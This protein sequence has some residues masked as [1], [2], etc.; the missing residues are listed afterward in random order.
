MN[1][2]PCR[3]GDGCRN[4]KC[5]FAHTNRMKC[6]YLSE[7]KSKLCTFDHTPAVIVLPKKQG[8]ISD[9]EISKRTAVIVQLLDFHV[10]DEQETM[11]DLLRN[12]MTEQTLGYK[13]WLLAKDLFCSGS[14][15]KQNFVPIEFIGNK[16]VLLKTL[17]HECRHSSLYNYVSDAMNRDRDFNVRLIALTTEGFYHT[18][19]ELK[20]ERRFILDA[21]R[22]NP[23]IYEFLHDKYK[24]DEEITI[25]AV[26][27][28]GEMLGCASKDLRAN[29][30]VVLH[31]VNN[32]GKALLFASTELKNDDSIAMAATKNN[33][34]AKQFA[35]RKVK[36]G[37]VMKYESRNER[38][39]REIETLMRSLEE[40]FEN[41]E[42]WKGEQFDKEKLQVIDKLERGKLLNRI[43]SKWGD[44]RDVILRA[45][46][47]NHE[48]LRFVRKKWK[49]DKEV[50][51]HA[52]RED[53]DALNYADPS[54]LNDRKFMLEL[55]S[56]DEVRIANRS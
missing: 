44:D 46:S 6:R 23:S 49:A 13:K 18:P 53:S 19:I 45:V 17:K 10:R 31:A 8:C 48:N 34:Q 16:E 30:N 14:T 26:K 5:L 37:R 20:K 15:L 25:E 42:D 56:E 41:L 22:T 21:V 1:Q 9:E 36:E 50:I 39:A 54:L 29:R 43:P 24:R 32:D 40:I 33:P 12:R 2:R 52:F 38:S 3:Y 55:I 47:I 7:C 4:A 28:K 11:Y 51:L 27:N 35:K